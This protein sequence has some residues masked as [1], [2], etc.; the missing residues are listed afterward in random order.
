M[1]ELSVLELAKQIKIVA[2]ISEKLLFHPLTDLSDVRLEIS[3]LGAYLQACETKLIKLMNDEHPPDTEP[4]S[5]QYGLALYFLDTTHPE[6]R[7]LLGLPETQITDA[8]L[9]QW[10]TE[11]EGPGAIDYDGSL[12]ARSKF[13]NLDA[14]WVTSLIYYIALKLDV[15][16]VSS[17]AQFGT[18]PATISVTGDTVKIA[19]IGDWGT[20]DWTDGSL[21][22]PALEVMTQVKSLAPDYTIHLGDVYYAGTAGFLTLMRKCLI[23]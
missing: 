19:V 23:S 18:T 22:S 9:E 3:R 14:G 5:T 16:E 4:G 12:I 6:F 8:M 11:I 10:K 17:W 1:S 15:R 20:G 7:R 2:Q 21:I 13:G